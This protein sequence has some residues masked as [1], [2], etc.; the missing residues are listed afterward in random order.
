MRTRH[1]NRGQDPTELQLKPTKVELVQ[2]R[3]AVEFCIAGGW[4]EILR[5]QKHLWR[6]LSELSEEDEGGREEVGVKSPGW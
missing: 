3:G 1:I 6:L 4:G 2:F 5:L